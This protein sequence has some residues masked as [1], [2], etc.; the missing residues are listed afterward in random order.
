MNAIISR[1]SKM[2]V[3]MNKL[4]ISDTGRPFPVRNV[5]RNAGV[6]QTL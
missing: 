1:A 4:G 5:A 6:A 2:R 3:V